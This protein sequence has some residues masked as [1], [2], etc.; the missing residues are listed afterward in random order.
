MLREESKSQAYSTVFFNLILPVNIGFV[1]AAAI[2]LLLRWM[3][4]EISLFLVPSQCYLRDAVL[5]LPYE[6]LSTHTFQELLN[7]SEDTDHVANDRVFF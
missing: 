5:D 1:L 7:F 4:I 2:H 3:G 6:E